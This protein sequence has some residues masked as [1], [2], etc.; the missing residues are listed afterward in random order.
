MD[1]ATAGAGWFLDAEPQAYTEFLN[2][3]EPGG[4]P[5]NYRRPN[6]KPKSSRG[7]GMDTFEGL[8]WRSQHPTILIFPLTRLRLG[9]GGGLGTAP[10]KLC[11]PYSIYRLL[12]A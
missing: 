2:I 11:T 10:G 1:L 7:M 12:F 6:L 5:T 4:S 8:A 3:P 9:G